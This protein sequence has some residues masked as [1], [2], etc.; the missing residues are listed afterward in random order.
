[1]SDSTNELMPNLSVGCEGEDVK[2]LQQ[3]LQELDFYSGPIDGL[4]GQ[5]TEQAVMEFE[6]SQ[7]FATDGVVG[8]FVLEA[9]GL[10][11]L[12]RDAE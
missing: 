9:L 2:K 4:F 6:D 7:G 11:T 1:M 5:G 10:V 12:E 3:R 8:V